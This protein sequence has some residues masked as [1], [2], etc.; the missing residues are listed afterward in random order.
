VPGRCSEHEIELLGGLWT[1]GL[2]GALDDLHVWGVG[3]VAPGGGGQRRTKLDARNSKAAAG[4]WN[5]RLAGGA[6]DLQELI[7]RSERSR[8]DERVVE[9]VGIVGASLL[10]EVDRRLERRPQLLSVVG[11]APIIARLTR[12]R[13]AFGDC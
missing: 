7:T 3:E 2:E 12:W 9:R 10:I 11:H 13:S 4:K 8:V 1:P 6:A 5:R